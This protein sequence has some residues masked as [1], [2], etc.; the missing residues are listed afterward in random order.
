M[1]RKNQWYSYDEMQNNA[2]EIKSPII[3]WFES[4]AIALTLVIVVFVFCIRIVIVFGPSMQNTLLNND[5]VAVQSFLYTP[6]RGD[7]IVIDSY[8]KYGKTLVKRIIAIEG[9]T[10]KINGTTGE[11]FVNDE[12]LAENYIS[13]PTAIENEGEISI[14]MPTGTVFV[15][16]D[17][18]A[19]S[20]D[21]RS[22]QIGLIDYRNI[23]GKVLFRIY[24]FYSIGVING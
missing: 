24:P 22:N 10:I 15:M 4:I 3:D 16:G 5:R 1:V 19:Q 18:R 8:T 6:K 21:S 12:I 17:N 2:A 20:L 23:L 7:V 11:V 9:D 13:S 14:T